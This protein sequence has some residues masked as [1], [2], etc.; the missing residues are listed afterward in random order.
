[1]DTQNRTLGKRWIRVEWG[2][3]SHPDSILKKSAE[4]KN[5][6]CKTV[7]SIDVELINKLFDKHGG[8]DLAKT[9]EG[10]DN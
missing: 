2:Y 10:I 1:M 4:D 5:N 8:L 9:M 7:G 6:I 3:P